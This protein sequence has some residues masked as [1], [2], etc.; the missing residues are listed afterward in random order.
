[1]REPFRILV[2]GGYGVF[3]SRI[4]AMLAAQGCDVLVAGRDGSKA[5]QMAEFIGLP[6]DNGLGLD[7]HDG[8]LAHV[9]S[10]RQV[11]LVIHTAG[12]FQGQGYTV[13]RAAIQAGAHYIDL[14]DGREFVSG[15][16]QLD[17]EA[18]QQ[19]VLVVSGASSLPALS[20]SVVDRYRARFQRID[21]IRLA[22]ASGARAPGLATMRGVFSYCGRPFM[23]W[24]N[25][26]WRKAW[27]W[28][29]TRY[30][31]FPGEVGGRFC[32]S[33]DVPD[34]V[35]FPKRYGA[36]T[37]TMHAGY[38]N[39]L[40]HLGIVG[41]SWLTRLHLLPGITGLVRPLRKI[42]EWTEPLISDKGGMEVMLTG[43]GHEG[44]TVT[45]KWYLLA[46]Q[47]HGPYIPC[48]ASVA[49]ALKLVRGMSMPTGAMACMGLVSTEE[50]LG[51]LSQ[52]DI[53][54]V[55]P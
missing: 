46:R 54:E 25:G 38:A 50:Y 8:T 18:R 47:N 51:A 5:R 43:V 9:L 20:S 41:L 39:A 30:I 37:V 26:E 22:I 24:E 53:T 49:L 35:L 21:Q 27:G 3:G 7:A 32:G 36:G 52:L 4:A 14:A 10:Q 19:H 42:S 6:S 17:E 33:C 2:L 48:G 23:R 13:A 45:L 28:L 40:S 11:N 12:P 16:S 44:E 15:I 29:D 31:A 55:T 34:L 1:M